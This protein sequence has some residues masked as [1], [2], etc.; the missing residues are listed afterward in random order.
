MAEVRQVML[1]GFGGQ[2]IVLG[3]T[4]LGY[5]A[6]N[7]GKWVS[8]TSSYG[9]A[10]RGGECASEV[11]ISDRP[12][13][14][15]HT[16]EV[17]LMIAMYQAAYDKYVGKVKPGTGMVIFDEQFVSPREDSSLKHIGVPATHIAEKELDSSMVANIVA[18]AAAIEISRAV[19][20]DAFT[21]A[22]KE[23]LPARFMELNLKAASLGF[24]LGQ[25][26]AA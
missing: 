9:P 12:V 5:A 18:L 7:D 15:P 11:V 20:R 1:C 13:T 21:S 24:Q 4:L 6:F 14:F 3:G 16:I 25:A 8:G 17:D 26:R 2:G 22:M 19:T 23:H 10:A